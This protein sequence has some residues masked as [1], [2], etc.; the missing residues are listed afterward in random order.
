MMDTGARDSDRESDADDDSDSQD[1]SGAE[2]DDADADHHDDRDEERER[3]DKHTGEPS[4]DMWAPSA[5]WR[6]G[7]TLWRVDFFTQVA[8]CDSLT[9]RRLKIRGWGGWWRPRASHHCRPWCSGW[10]VCD[11]RPSQQYRLCQSSFRCLMC[12]CVQVSLSRRMRRTT[13]M[14][15]TTQTLRSR[16][17]RIRS[18]LK[19]LSHWSIPDFLFRRHQWQRSSLLHTCRLHQSQGLLL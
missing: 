9:C 4:A 14:K 19:P 12:V 5:H 11:T 18:P 3:G 8:A 7:R 15:R 1:D 13:R 6:S 2:R 10:Q 17:L 16:M